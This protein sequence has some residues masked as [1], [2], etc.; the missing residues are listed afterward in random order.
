MTEFLPENSD[1]NIELRQYRDALAISGGVVIAFSLWDM[2]KV[3]IGFFLGEETI[4]EIVSA[5]MGKE[6]LPENEI[7]AQIRMWV[8][9]IIVAAIIVIFT[10]I[11][12]YHLYIGLNA[13]REGRGKAKKKRVVYLGLT[14]VSCICSAVVLCINLAALFQADQTG[15][16]VGYATFLLEISSLLNYIY[17]IY[18][19]VKIRKL[20]RETV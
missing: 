19:A 12:L 5:S 1:R 3:L 7:G 11:L 9:V 13:Y 16:Q 6:Q 2:L 10:L 4:S 15:T 14:V 18:S 8:W 20:E 17:L